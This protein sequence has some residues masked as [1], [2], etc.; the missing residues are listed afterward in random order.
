MKTDNFAQSSNICNNMLTLGPSM[1]I[2][3]NAFLEPKSSHNGKAKLDKS[4]QDG[5]VNC[6]VSTQATPM[7]NILP[8]YTFIPTFTTNQNGTYD[9]ASTSIVPTTTS[10]GYRTS[11]KEPENMAQYGSRTSLNKLSYTNFSGSS[12]EMNLSMSAE[13]LTFIAFKPQPEV[14]MLEAEM[15][16]ETEESSDESESDASDNEEMERPLVRDWYKDR[17]DA[18]WKWNWLQ[19]RKDGLKEEMRQC[20][21]DRRE[22][23]MKKEKREPQ[24]NENVPK[25]CQ[26]A[27][28]AGIAPISKNRELFEYNHLELAEDVEDHG[29]SIFIPRGNKRQRQEQEDQLNAKVMQ[30]K[31]RG[32]RRSLNLKNCK[33]K[34]KGEINI[35]VPFYLMS[36]KPDPH[37]HSHH[38]PSDK[39]SLI[40]TPTCKQV[41]HEF[42]L[43]PDQ[44]FETAILKMKQTQETQIT[45]EE[46]QETQNA[47][48]K[49][50][51]E[52]NAREE[53]AREEI[54]REET[55][56]TSR[57]KHRKEKSKK[58]EKKSSKPRITL[59][60]RRPRSAIDAY[61]L[62]YLNN[63][64]KKGIIPPFAS[65]RNDTLPSAPQDDVQ[66][67]TCHSSIED[68]GSDE[69]TSDESY[70][71]KHFCRELLEKRMML[72]DKKLPR[73]P[74][75][76]SVE[77]FTEC[78]FKD[79]LLPWK[80]QKR[81][82]AHL[83][84]AENSA[85]IREKFKKL[86][87][88]Y[89]SQ[90]A[91]PR[92]QQDFFWENGEEFSEDEEF[93]GNFDEN[94]ESWEISPG[95]S[96]PLKFTIR[97]TNLTL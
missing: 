97:R 67:E 27:R 77:F 86:R 39:S 45:R 87:M 66:D 32:S 64:V 11:V 78:E 93:D 15:E 28:T 53:I 91:G 35:V 4:A 96:G 23:R 14:H 41:Q 9:I 79:Y 19:L 40:Y 48:E 22:L 46:P 60:C 16:A 80:K 49:I 21:Q 43:N 81:K 71:E 17:I 55:Q 92:W 72:W 33:N 26:S 13:D 62:K 42:K 94:L 10:H 52:E 88:R 59:R 25:D 90:P 70:A 2:S 63:D 75:E 69:D 73:K 47:R 8:Y 54:T 61:I 38:T 58:R 56:K 20:D 36:T 51:R 30:R 3:R 1:T 95:E 31:K 37:A 24:W 6:S 68:D 65:K 85:K 76:L 50:A 29:Y 18:S 34:A 82:F 84:L 57:K 89:Q 74:D 83:T 7:T 44:A 5:L 12:H